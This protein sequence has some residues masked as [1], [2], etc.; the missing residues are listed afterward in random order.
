MLEKVLL[1]ESL[2]QQHGFAD[3]VNLVELLSV[4]ESRL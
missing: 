3:L 4:P 1:E 2:T